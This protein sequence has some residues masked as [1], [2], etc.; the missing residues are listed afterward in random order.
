MWKVC[1]RAA[2]LVFPLLVLTGGTA[3][4]LTERYASY[5]YNY[6]K[7]PVPSPAYY[8]PET[9]MDNKTLALTDPVDLAVSDG[10]VYVLDAGGGERDS[11]SK[12]PAKVVAVNSDFQVIRVIEAFDNNG[13]TDTFSYPQGIFCTEDGFLYIADTGNGRIVKLTVSGELVAVFG[14]PDTK[15]L[16]SSITYQPKKIAV[17]P[18][19]RMYV[20][21]SSV[22]QGLMV[23]EKDGKFLRFMGANSVKLN[24]G[25][26]I[27]RMFSTEEQRK[28]MELFVPTEY[29]NVAIDRMGFVFAVSGSSDR[30][31]AVIKRLNPKGKDVLRRN[32]YIP[33]VGDLVEGKIYSVLVD[34]AVHQSGLYA[35]VDSITG[36][37]FMYDADGNLVIAFGGKGEILGHVMVPVALD[38]LGDRLLLLD[39]YTCTV[40]CFKLTAFGRAVHEAT[41]AVQTGDY[42]I[43]DQKWREAL[44]YNANY[45]LAYIG[46][47]KTALQSGRYKEA[48]SYFKLAENRDY[49]SKAYQRYRKEKSAKI[50]PYAATVLLIIA[51]LL[52][53]RKLLKRL[54][55]LYKRL[56]VDYGK[57]IG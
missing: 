19:G 5:T 34:V 37:V 44:Q 11:A 14:R 56:C 50:F 27:W 28:R 6:W 24:I 38:F 32:G 55:N 30:N 20:V 35:V 23:L 22:N 49:Y 54:I 2:L 10:I 18:V 13:K 36:R 41:M 3:A 53:L 47:G 9:Q 4:A 29:T 45:D 25:Q 43:A 52:V 12:K 48:V 57:E 8:E 40:Q 26:Y 16:D 1:R 31:D 51:G 7:D 33:T 46:L 17:D 42:D 21:A 15:M 39:S